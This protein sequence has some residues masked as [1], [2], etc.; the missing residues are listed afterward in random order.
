MLP[1]RSR[2]RRWTA[3]LIGTMVGL[4]LGWIAAGYAQ[5]FL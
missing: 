3:R 5:A 1:K 2:R 4:T